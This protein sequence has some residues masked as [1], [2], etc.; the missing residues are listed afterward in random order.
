[1]RRISVFALLRILLVTVALG[2][3]TIPRAA[4]ADTRDQII[5]EMK[6]QGFTRITVQGTLLGRTR[7]LA[8]R[9]GGRR[10]VVINP[11]T[12]VILR[13]YTSGLPHRTHSTDDDWVTTTRSQT[14]GDSG[15]SSSQGD[16]GSATS[17]SS[18]D[19]GTSDDEG[20]GGDGDQGGDEDSGDEG[21]GDGGDSG[22]GE[23]NDGGDEDGGADDD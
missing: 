10:E 8:E 14:N 21:A 20:E 7:I 11:R 6:E 18:G 9:Q 23:N 19:M 13:D 17:V 1:M 4:L 12:G 22:N 3:V 15:L 16:R 5:T 2:G